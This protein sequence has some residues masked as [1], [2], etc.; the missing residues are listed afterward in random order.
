MPGLQRGDE[1]GARLR[2][3]RGEGDGV[4]ALGGAAARQGL[5][6]QNGFGMSAAASGEWAGNS[7]RYQARFEIWRVIKR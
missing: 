4:H 1:I 3:M 5:G 6:A 7:W 2:E